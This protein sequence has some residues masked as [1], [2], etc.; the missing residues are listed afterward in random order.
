MDNL[1]EPKDKFTMNYK[2]ETGMV[3]ANKVFKWVDRG[4]EESVVI[5]QVGQ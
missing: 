1:G 5:D 3:E 2:K 4:E